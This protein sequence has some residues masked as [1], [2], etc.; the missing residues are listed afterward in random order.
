MDFVNELLED[1]IKGLNI[2]KDLIINTIKA[3]ALYKKGGWELV[4]SELGDDFCNPNFVMNTATLYRKLQELNRN[5]L[6]NIQQNMSE[7][8]NLVNAELKHKIVAY[9]VDR[10]HH[11][12]KILV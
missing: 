7:L 1:K 12:I 4:K 6:I 10:K 3:K 9:E 11:Y 8:V 5:P 2:V